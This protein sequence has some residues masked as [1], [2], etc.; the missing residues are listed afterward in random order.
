M[1][2]LLYFF[3]F[4]SAKADLPKDQPPTGACAPSARWRASLPPPGRVLVAVQVPGAQHMARPATPGA[5]RRLEEVGWLCRAQQLRL[6]ASQPS[7][8][9]DLDLL[10]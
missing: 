1:G 8:S 3:Q 5:G 4:V 6:A 10:G 7:L 2:F 9:R